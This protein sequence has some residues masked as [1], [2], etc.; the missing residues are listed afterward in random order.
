A[1]QTK[2]EGYDRE[3]VLSKAKGFFGDVSEGLAKAVERAFSDYG[4]PVG[5]I[6]GDEGGGAIAIGLRYGSGTLHRKGQADLPVWWQGPSIGFDIGGNA[7]KVF[8][9]IYGMSNE[10]QLFQRFPSVDGSLY[11]VAGFGL[12]YQTTD[13]VVLAPIRSGVGARAG[14]SI[15]YLH[16]T[17][18]KHLNPL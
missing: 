1:N 3:E 9:L 6:T 15:G 18:E 17:R 14:A 7:A 12:T 2:T 13:G 10:A 16:Y 11:I 4:A 5:Y 8:T